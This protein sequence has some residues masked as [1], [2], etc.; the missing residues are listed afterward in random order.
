VVEPPKPNAAR[1]DDEDE[2][3]LVKASS[4][5]RLRRKQGR[6]ARVLEDD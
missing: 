5:G 1:T 3:R 6:D 4:G 2:D